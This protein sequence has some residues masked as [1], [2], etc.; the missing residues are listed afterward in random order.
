MLRK[1]IDAPD[2]KA[3]TCGLSPFV[4]TAVVV[5]SPAFTALKAELTEAVRAEVLAA[6]A[7]M[8]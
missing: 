2:G 6:Q 8:P 4:A 3:A 1:Q 5:W 7:T